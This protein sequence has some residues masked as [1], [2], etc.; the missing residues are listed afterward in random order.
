MPIIKFTARN[1]VAPYRSIALLKKNQNTNTFRHP[2]GANK[3]HTSSSACIAFTANDML[4]NGTRIISGTGNPAICS[5]C[6]CVYS[7]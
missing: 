5:S 6:S 7:L 3:E 2:Q 1:D 4:S